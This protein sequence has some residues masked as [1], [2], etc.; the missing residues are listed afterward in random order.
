LITSGN[1]LITDVYKD[2]DLI[3]RDNKMKCA[4]ILGRL[5]EEGLIER[6]GERRGS[7][8]IVD[9]FMERMNWIDSEG[10]LLDVKYPFGLEDYVETMRKNIIV[11][12]GEANSGKTAFMLN[13]IRLNMY[14]FRVHYFNSEMGSHEL[15]KRLV[16]FGIPL[17]NWKFHAW[18]RS[19]NFEDVIRPDA[20]NIIDFLELSEEFYK[21][22][23][24][25]KKI[26]DK[27][28]TGIAVIALQKNK[29]RDEGIGGFR[30]LEKPRLY[31]AMEPNKLKIVKAKNWVSDV[32]NPNGLEVNFKLVQG[33]K[34]I[35]DEK[36]GWHPS[37]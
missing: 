25:I 33:C 6:Y 14:R 2:L 29:G 7:Y 23:G 20:I 9:P 1:F 27:L 31:L 12:A 17:E 10:G 21:V 13:L 30:T 11:V 19:R 32:I 18:E 15:K 35:P 16:K 8:R 28:T 3:T 34:F 26:F 4:T 37:E 24:I 5:V 22:S 36:I